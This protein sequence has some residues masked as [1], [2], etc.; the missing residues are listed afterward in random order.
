[1]SGAESR[2]SIAITSGLLHADSR[3][4]FRVHIDIRIAI[5]LLEDTQAKAA[6]IEKQG[7]LGG[8]GAAAH[9]GPVAQHEVLN[10]SAD[11]PGGIGGETNLA[12]GFETGRGFK[13]AHMAFLDKIGD[14]QAVIA[15]AAAMAMDKAHMRG[16]Q[17]VE[18]ILVLM[19]SPSD[20]EGVLVLP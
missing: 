9:D 4:D 6:E 10:G 1:M 17:L 7:L 13:E 2:A 11:P 3:R 15:E 18:G 14:G 5:R 12:I 20:S 19:V 16:C 8:A